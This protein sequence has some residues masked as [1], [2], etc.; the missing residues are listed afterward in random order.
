MNM[1][2]LNTCICCCH[3]CVNYIDRSGGWG[4]K[5]PPPPPPPH[6]WQSDHTYCFSC[7]S[8]SGK[9]WGPF[10]FLPFACQFKIMVPPPPPPPPWWKRILDLPLHYNII[11]VL[12]SLLLFVWNNAKCSF[13][14][15][16]M[17]RIHFHTVLFSHS[18]TIGVW[19]PW[20]SGIWLWL[21]LL[22]WGTSQSQDRRGL[23]GE[24]TMLLLN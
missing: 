13:S 12:Q 4:G 5:R 10:S 16:N 11:L 24:L 8:H 1:V 21:V 6:R 9:K 14:Y 19:A 2:N 20:L 7:T 15:I 22:P 18:D 17:K 23:N 3:I